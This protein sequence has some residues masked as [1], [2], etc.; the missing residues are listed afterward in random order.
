VDQKGPATRHAW[1]PL[2]RRYPRDLPVEAIHAGVS[3]RNG[4]PR[5]QLALRRD[6]EFG[7]T[8]PVPEQ[9]VWRILEQQ[10]T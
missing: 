7:V 2:T 10:V 8:W 4:M 6:D 3:V 1:A 5:D 9:I